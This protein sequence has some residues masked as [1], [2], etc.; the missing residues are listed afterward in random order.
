MSNQ[1]RDGADPV[2]DFS[3]SI[4]VDLF[5]GGQTPGD[6]YGIVRFQIS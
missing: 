4:R 2:Q 1:A 5:V 3:L 6:V